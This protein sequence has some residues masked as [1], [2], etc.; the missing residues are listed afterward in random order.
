MLEFV[1]VEYYYDSDM[2]GATPA[3]RDINLKIEDGE[4]VGIIGHTGSG[5]STLVQHMN[6]LL[7]PTKG[8]YIYDGTVIDAKSGNLKELRAKVGLVFQYPEHQLFEATVLEDVCFGP[9]NMGLTDDECKKRAVEALDKVGVDAKYYD[10]S[11]FELSG[12]QKRR[13]A[14]AG[15]LAMS[16]RV[17]V[18]DEPTA[19]LDPE[20]R[21]DLL[22]ML[23]TLNDEGMTI[24]LVSHSMDD[25]AKYARRLVVIDNAYIAFDGTP[26][27]VFSHKSELV[28]MGLNVPQIT[29]IMQ[30]LKSNGFDVDDTLFDV[31]AAAESIMKCLDRK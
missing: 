31:D 30:S 16:P 19:G 25:V 10:A 29:G 7:N 11:P 15:V 22:N 28:N 4:F 20:G 24:V 18:L 2:P 23:K 26:T 14:I 21:H 13:V 12:G 27:E 9:K 5:K 3:L 1:D 6:G 17:L 8:K